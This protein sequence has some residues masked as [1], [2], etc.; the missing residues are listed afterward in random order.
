MRLILTF[1]ASIVLTAC[2]SGYQSF[3]RPYDD[4]KKLPD[5]R[6]LSEG[7]KP[8]I[9]SSDDLDRD[10]R[11][12]K[13]KSYQP[14]GFSSF[15]GKIES[16][17]AVINQARNVG[18][19]LVLVNSK[20]TEN[21]AI[22]TPLF[23]PNNQTTYYS[24]T[25]SGSLNGTYGRSNYTG[26]YTGNTTG[27]S[28]TYGTTVV[29][30]T[31]YQQRFDQTAVFFV[32][33]TRK[34]KFGLIVIDLS[35]ELRLKYERNTGAVIDIVIEESPAFS[36]NVL[37]GDILIDINSTPVVNGKQAVELM[38]HVVDILQSGSLKDDK[39]IINVI[40]NGTIKSIELQLTKS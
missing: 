32:K 19:V 21:R 7:E 11:V 18:A 10:V 20:F 15:N 12:A 9:Y 5:V 40:R 28:T 1:I 16:E 3:Y 25:T 37:P 22:T 2:A 8:A 31:T 34:W 35:P 26:N 27:T 33:S 17:Q 6:L 14:I 23:V 38:Y 13:S 24:G 30:M 39:C 36:A 4:A 29:P